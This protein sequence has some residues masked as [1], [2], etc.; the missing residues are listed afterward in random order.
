VKKIKMDEEQSTIWRRASE[1]K[2]RVALR[3]VKF[4]LAIVLKA[5]LAFA[6]EN[7]LKQTA[8]AR[9]QAAELRHL[10]TQEKK[11]LKHLLQ[12]AR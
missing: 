6:E 7:V 10:L 11:K 8:E 2:N 9:K 4:L 5:E 12:N 1:V 3:V